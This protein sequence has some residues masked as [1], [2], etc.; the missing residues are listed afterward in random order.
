MAVRPDYYIVAREEGERPHPW[1][2][3]IRRHSRPLGV[4]V[5][6]CGFQSQ[7]AA[8]F[9]GRKALAEFLDDLAKEERRR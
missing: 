3:E 4:R 6:E 7:S 1:C 2:W 8:E 5:R 9:A